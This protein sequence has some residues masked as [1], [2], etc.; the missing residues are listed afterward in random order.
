MT[1]YQE[2]A[3]EFIQDKSEFTWD[4]IK[5]DLLSKGVALGT[6]KTVTRELKDKGV[7]QS[8][9]RGHY[10]N[11]ELALQSIKKLDNIMYLFIQSGTE[12]YKKR[13]H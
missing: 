9:K 6:I 1:T 10:I 3:V 5:A 13:I 12:Q 11:T 8:P 2:M 7:I 4:E